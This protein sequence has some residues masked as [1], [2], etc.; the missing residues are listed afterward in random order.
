M[1]STPLRG[2]HLEG[3]IDVTAL[4]LL[5]IIHCTGADIGKATELYLIF[6]PED[7][8]IQGHIA[9]DDPDIAP[10]F[11]MLCELV[12]LD[13]PEAVRP[14]KSVMTQILEE[15]VLAPT[16]GYAEEKKA[17]AWL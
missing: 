4:K 5:A 15:R 8:K 12:L 14:S 13:A 17:S 10:S 3:E 11:A 9:A 7:P 2:R 1:L 6:K 16:F